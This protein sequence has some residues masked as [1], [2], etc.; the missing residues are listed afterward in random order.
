MAAIGS[1]ARVMLSAF[2]IVAALSVALAAG[3]TE[4]VAQLRGHGGP[5]RALAIAADGQTAISGSF[6][7]TAIRWSLARNAAEQVLR[8]HADAVNAVALLSP[9]RAAT[10]GA[11]GRIAIWTLGKTEPDAVLEGHTAPIAALAVSPD[12]A[13]LA[14]A[15]WDHTVRLWPLAGGAPRVLDGHTQNVNGV[16][17]TAD[18]RAVISVSYDLSVR[19]W[20]LSGAQAPAVVPMPTPLN[21][22]ATGADGEIAVGGA[23]GKVYFL[24]AGGAPAGEVAAGPRPVISIAISPDGAL[25]AA[26]GIGGTVAVID[27]K[28]RTL[29]RTLVGPG[30]P[31]WSVAFMPDSRTLLTGGADSII[32]RWNAATGEPVDPILLETAG[33][34]LAAYAGDRG[35]EIFR[36]C[37][38]CHTLGADQA[39]RAGPTLSGIF[40]R[41]IATASGYDF[42]DALKRLDIVWTPETVS[43]LFEVGPQAYTP[44]TKMPEQRIGSEQDRAALVQFLQRATKK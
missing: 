9:G 13:T 2:A 5:V 33:D 35:A 34:P 43:K 12:G 40:G 17:F 26:A 27:R 42:S 1:F 28:A 32:R 8:F 23:D 6:D 16:A 10:A 30:L 20:P 41:R 15:S 3:T 19:I 7:S 38:A 22:V 29:A 44:G 14:S 31:V 21:A 11:D 37:V 24:T 39:N 25:L 18:G 4:A 36:A